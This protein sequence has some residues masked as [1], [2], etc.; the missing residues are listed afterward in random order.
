MDKDDD[1]DFGSWKIKQLQVN[2]SCACLGPL[3]DPRSRTLT[4]SLRS[5]YRNISESK[6]ATMKIARRNKTSLTGPL[7]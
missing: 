4:K 7:S 6:V 3:F 2:I 5:Q 1:A